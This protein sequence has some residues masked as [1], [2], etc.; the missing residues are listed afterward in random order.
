MSGA[1][2]MPG[3]LTAGAL[4]VWAGLVKLRR[5]GTAEVF[6]ASL[7]VPAP[8]LFVRAGALLELAAGGG[9]LFR[10]QLAAVAVALL[11]ALFAVLVAI[12]LR[13]Q[14]G[15]PCGCLGADTGPASHFHLA[16]NL[17]C[18][19]LAGAAALAPPPAYPSLAASDP[20]AAAT[21]G[22][23]AVSVALLAVAAV[24]LLPVTMGA[25]RGAEM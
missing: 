13:Q 24:N 1:P 18:V 7:G 20:F 22:F 4:F 17:V 15:V 11:Y 10:P 3:L 25:W 6:L 8:R 5:P 23:V 14:T 16:L 12:Q 21:V 2:L 9:V 19:A